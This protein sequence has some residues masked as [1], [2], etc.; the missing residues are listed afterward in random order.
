MQFRGSKDGSGDEKAKDK[1]SSGVKDSFVRGRDKVRGQKYSAQRGRINVGKGDMDG[2][3][4]TS[5]P[6][7]H[8]M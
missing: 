7:E 3:V 2:G 4:T 6:P 8:Y 1:S 5:P